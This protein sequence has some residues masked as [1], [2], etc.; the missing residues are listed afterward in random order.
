[1]NRDSFENLFVLEMTNNHQ[2]SLERGLAIIREH[3]RIV[4]FNNVR[5]AIKL[6]F[7]DVDS[8]V[9]KDFRDREDIR[10]I[11]RVLDTKLRKSDYE[12]MVVAI[13][14]S[15][16]IPMATPFDEKSV[17]WCEEFDLP[18]IKIASADSNDW[19][20][21]E[22]IAKTRKPCIISFGGTPLKDMDDVVTFFENRNIPLAINHCVAA[23]P[24]EDSEAEL[25]QVDFL[26]ERYPGHT[27]GYSCH[28]R[29]DWATSVM[30]AYGKGARTFERHIDINSDGFQ[31]ASYSSLPSQIDTW[32][33]A[34]H[35]AVTFCGTS[36]TGRK[37]PLAKETA[38]L[39]SYIRGVYAH[40]DLQPGEMLTED[41]IY[42]AIPLQKGQ[43][44]CRELMLGR[45]GHRMTA[46]C[47][48]DAPVMIDMIDSPYAEDEQLKAKIYER[49]L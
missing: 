11:R 6:Q 34:F 29:G 19:L 7:R 28:E 24:H 32:F 21:L 10:Y 40:R 36:R 5:A 47:A 27:I 37:L 25:E 9:H 39:D 26:R 3:S 41:D 13:R 17:D 20:L 12:E 30:I 35:R 23:Y 18:I 33:K 48:K 1:M 46:V 16:C 14:K 38:Y 42:M 45:Y 44:S 43:L 15:G 8:F 22:R 31:P 49:G 4:R 2:G